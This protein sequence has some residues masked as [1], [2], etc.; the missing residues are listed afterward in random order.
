M[1]RR[2]R[3]TW[4]GNVKR[5]DLAQRAAVALV[6]S[7]VV[8]DEIIAVRLDGEIAVDRLGNEPLLAA[9]LRGEPLER[10]LELLAHRA[11]V[12]GTRSATAPLQPEQLIEIQERKD[13][14]QRDVAQHARAV[15]RH[16]G[17]GHVGAHGDSAPCW[18][19]P[20][21]MSLPTV[22]CRNTSLRASSSV[23][24]TAWATAVGVHQLVHHGEAFERVLAVVDARASTA[25][26][27][28]R[29][30]CAGR[31]VG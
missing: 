15:E 12:R 23:R 27:R 20:A 1:Q 4:R 18:R 24:A 2:S 5:A 31:T 22:V 13:L 10:G 30:A 26:R 11:L 16:R 6:R 7:G 14:R 3:P 19:D 28:R 9:G 21:A 17:E 29:R 25:A 8:H